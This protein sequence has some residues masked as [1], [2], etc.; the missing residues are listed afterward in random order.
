MLRHE[1]KRSEDF[2]ASADTPQQACLAGVRWAE[3]VVLLLGARY[4]D[5]QTSGISATHEEYREAKSRCPVLAFVQRDVDRE[6]AEQDLVDEVRGW[7]SGV[8]TGDF[9]SPEELHDAVTRAMHELELMQQPGLLDEGELAERAQALIPDRYGLQAATLCVATACGPR[10]QILRPSALDEPSL[11]RDLHREVLLGEHAVFDTTQGVQVRLTGEAIL[12]EQ[13]RA[14]LMVDSLG[15]VRL[16]QPAT[17]AGAAGLPVL[18]EE[19]VGD[20]LARS[21]RL[22]AWILD[23][24]DPVR[25]LSHVA[26]TVALLS[27]AYLGWR[28]RDEH[29]ASPNTVQM[30]MNVGD[31]VVVGLT[32]AVRPRAALTYEVPELAEDFIALLRR[33]YR[34]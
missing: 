27:A 21:F 2:G 3:V 11:E 12:L 26:P 32:P 24:I 6:A 9:A 34:A 10:Q 16:I 19:E 13:A 20:R 23:R 17:D 22:T 14:S 30:P 4:G 15:S 33:I 8:L 28:T 29:A 25:R 18:I 1:V 5:R 7:A 31:R